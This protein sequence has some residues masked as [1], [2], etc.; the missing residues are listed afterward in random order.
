MSQVHIRY[1]GNS[2]D[3]DANVIDVGVLS[4]DAQI[5]DALA[6][7]LD[8]PVVKFNGYAVERNNETGDITVRPQ[9]VFG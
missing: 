2:V 3:V 9:A 6:T 7:H 5:K 4:T 1:D 8:V